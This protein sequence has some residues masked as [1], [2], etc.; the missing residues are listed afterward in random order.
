MLLMLGFAALPVRINAT[1]PVHTPLFATLEVDNNAVIVI[2][3]RLGREIN[4]KPIA[5]GE[6]NEYFLSPLKRGNLAG[7]E[8][9][10]LF[11]PEIDKIALVTLLSGKP[12]S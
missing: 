10:V 7:C 5:C 6:L 8:A 4:R 3:Y 1:I 2:A 11:S 9:R 12:A